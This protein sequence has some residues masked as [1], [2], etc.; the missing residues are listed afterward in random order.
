MESQSKRVGKA[1]ALKPLGRSQTF[2]HE[3]EEPR[4]K[5]QKRERWTGPC[6]ELPRA[7]G[8]SDH[9]LGIAK[10]CEKLWDK[11]DGERTEP[12]VLA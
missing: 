9:D 7:P 5:Q 3:P 10:E 6:I 2:L 12:T 4:A 8:M 1:Q 11:L